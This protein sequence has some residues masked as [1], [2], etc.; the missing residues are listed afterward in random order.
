MITNKE[1]LEKLIEQIKRL[2]ILTEEVRE[3]DIYPISF[4]SQAFDISNKIQEDIQQIEVSQIELIESH[5]KKQQAPQLFTQQEMIAPAIVPPPSNHVQE[6][7]AL[8]IAPSP[9]QQVRDEKKAISAY[10]SGKVDRI[11][12]KKILTLNDRFLFCRE[13]FA[14]DETLMNQIFGELNMEES[15]E[16]SI[17]YLQKRFDWDFETDTVT[18][19]LAVL[20]KK[21]T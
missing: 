21:F 2:E 5:V 15:Y 20:K 12:L 10:S 1:R 17:E 18:D 8:L 19:F 7:V 6:T 16:A 3:R 14:N 9:V 11:D 13:L 4:F